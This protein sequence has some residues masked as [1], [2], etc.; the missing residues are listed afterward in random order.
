MCSFKP[1]S[2]GLHNCSLRLIPQS[3]SISVFSKVGQFGTA[4][5]RYVNR[6]TNEAA[7]G[8]GQG[9]LKNNSSWF[10][11][12]KSTTAISIWLMY[13]CLAH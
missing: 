9:A 8:W 4:L 2:H 12:T 5:L 10:L 1:I 6:L 11:V 7:C 13:W 3:K